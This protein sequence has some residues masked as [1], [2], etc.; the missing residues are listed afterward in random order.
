VPGDVEA[1][2]LIEAIRYGSAEMPPDGKLPDE[3]I[4]DFETWVRMGAPDPRER[5]TRR[6]PAGAGRRRASLL[7]VPAPEIP[8]T[9]RG[10]G[11]RL[12]PPPV[13]AFILARLERAGIGPSPEAGAGR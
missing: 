7:V 3:V 6:T 2:P 8:S 12:G 4:A 10:P 9:P 11:R 13:D 1:S 5:R